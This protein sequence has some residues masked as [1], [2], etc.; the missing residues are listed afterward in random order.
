MQS[1]GYSVQ[2]SRIHT[3]GATDRAPLDATMYLQWNVMFS[4]KSFGISFVLL[5]LNAQEA[6]WWPDVPKLHE[7]KTAINPNNVFHHP[8]SVRPAKKTQ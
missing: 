3:G 6:Y 7:V 4:V 8:Q 5:L 2:M 1:T